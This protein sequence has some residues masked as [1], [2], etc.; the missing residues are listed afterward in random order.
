MAREK[1]VL[2]PT[3]SELGFKIRHMM[4]TNV[5]GSFKSF[6]VELERDGDDLTKAN[7]TLT[8]DIASVFTNNAQR[9][10]HLLASDFFEADK[11][12]QL[13]FTS[14]KIERVDDDSYTVTGDLTLK[15]V[16]KPIKLNV[17]H[18]GSVAKDPW[19]LERAGYSVTGKIPR[20]E[21]GVSFNSVLDSGGVGLGE[22]V[23][24]VS[25]IQ[26]V[27]Q[28]ATVPAEAALVS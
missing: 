2:D 8:A 18:T 13:K 22:E 1:W 7:I 24:L 27:K 26:L 12:P 21:W 11:H 17:E 19:G 6:Q 16:T 14:T 28:A 15:G 20:N 25:E 3:H 9:D 10:A 4:L 5:S 23:K